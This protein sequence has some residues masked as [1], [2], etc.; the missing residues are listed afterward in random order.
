MPV[1]TLQNKGRQKEMGMLTA[2]LRAFG[3]KFGYY[4]PRS[5]RQS[6]L[7]DPI[8]DTWSDVL[9]AQA[10]IIY[11]TSSNDEQKKMLIEKYIFG[12]VTN[13]HNMCER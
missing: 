9:I 10:R 3:V 6:L 4:N 8:I 11:D 13:F 12:I 7:I 2:T 1:M 5:W